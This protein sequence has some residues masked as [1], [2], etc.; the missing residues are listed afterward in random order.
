MNIKYELNLEVFELGARL[1][2]IA[3]WQGLISLEDA[4]KGYS[5]KLPQIQLEFYSYGISLIASGI[6]PEL[7]TFLLAEELEALKDV[8]SAASLKD[9]RLIKRFIH[10]MQMGQHEHCLSLLMTLNDSSLKSR[11]K[12]WHFLCQY[13]HG[14]SVEVAN[15]LGASDVEALRN[16]KPHIKAFHDQTFTGEGLTFQLD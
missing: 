4:I 3:R 1:S 16:T 6:D 13:D 7:V 10:W 15:K 2:N 8:A 9:L 11:Y 5:R 14:I 12:A